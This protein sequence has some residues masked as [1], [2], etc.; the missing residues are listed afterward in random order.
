MIKRKTSIQRWI[1]QHYINVREE[2]QKQAPATQEVLVLYPKVPSQ[3]NLNK[4]ECSQEVRVT[5]RK[6]Q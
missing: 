5:K 3:S 6:Q 1:D 4:M 2:A